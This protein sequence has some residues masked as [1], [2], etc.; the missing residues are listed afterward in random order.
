[1]TKQEYDKLPSNGK[2]PCPRCLSTSTTPCP[3][4]GCPVSDTGY[5][6]KHINKYHHRCPKPTKF[7]DATN[8]YIEK[9]G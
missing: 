1:M 5:G 4:C 8:D 3:G 6:I 7:Y 9:K 2:V